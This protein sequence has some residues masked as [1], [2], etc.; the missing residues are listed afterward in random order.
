M[1]RK[2]E[3]GVESSVFMKPAPT[4]MG[5][6]KKIEKET[7]FSSP[8]SEA[9][10]EEEM[11]SD[12]DKG[13]DE[14]AD[15]EENDNDETCQENDDHVETDYFFCRHGTQDGEKLA[16]RST[17]CEEKRPEEFEYIETSLK[18][19]TKRSAC[20]QTT[21]S[22]LIGVEFRSLAKKS[23]DSFNQLQNVCPHGDAFWRKSFEN[24]FHD[25]A[26]AWNFQ[27]HYREILV[28]TEIYGLQRVEIGRMGCM[29]AELWF[30]WFL[31]SND[32]KY[33]KE[34]HLF[35]ST[36]RN[37]AYFGRVAK[38]SQSAK[39]WIE[40]FRFYARFIIVCAI[41]HD[42]P[43]IQK[44]VQE[45]EYLVKRTRVIPDDRFRAVV[46]QWTSVLEEV[47]R[48]RHL[49]LYESRCI[50]RLPPRVSIRDT[51]H[52][53]PLLFECVF[54]ESRPQQVKFSEF[55]VD[56]LRMLR[57]I[58]Q[59]GFISR[60][61]TPS[62]DSSCASD[63]QAESIESGGSSQ[64]SQHQEPVSGS[65]PRDGSRDQNMSAS[66][67][68]G[69]SHGTSMIGGV[70]VDTPHPVGDGSLRKDPFTMDAG[71]KHDSRSGVRDDMEE[72]RR[73]TK[74]DEVRRES[75]AEEGMF[76]EMEMDDHQQKNQKTH[77][78]SGRKQALSTTQEATERPHV[79]VLY[80]PSV[81]ELLTC[82]NMAFL[83]VT[84][85]EKIAPIKTKPSFLLYF[86]CNVV[87]RDAD[88]WGIALRDMTE[89]LTFED[90][91]PIAS[92]FPTVII[93]ESNFPSLFFRKSSLPSNV[94]CLCDPC[95]RVDN[96]ASL[97]SSLTLPTSSRLGQGL[98][99]QF[100]RSQHGSLLTLFL[101]H[102]IFAVAH[103]SGC[104]SAVFDR[105]YD[106]LDAMINTF[107]RE[108]YMWIANP[109]VSRQFHPLI[110]KMCSDEN[111]LNIVIRF[112]FCV[113]FLWFHKAFKGNE[114]DDELKERERDKEREVHEGRRG[115]SMNTYSHLRL[116][117][118]IPSLS[119]ALMKELC[120][121]MEIHVQG[122]AEL[123]EIQ[124]Q[125]AFGSV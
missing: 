24:A 109:V 8:K 63:D 99:A 91:Q 43:M 83:D 119:V 25:L 47:S 87:E 9:N 72:K 62:G 45:L 65:F 17:E 28:H 50:R 52:A 97:A 74:S 122:V 101:Y 42:A 35:Y 40:V 73:E 19:E 114:E 96:P 64:D 46:R 3:N 11:E 15:D 100:R 108:I 66:M 121:R 88:S 54:V 32:E 115:S 41:L 22:E 1:D 49:Y 70:D 34:S 51:G 30:H 18:E 33:L 48:F 125:F 58:R 21:L 120:D 98:L 60:G 124:E 95:A 31:R 53:K 123:L 13:D 37:R 104:S 16:S 39:D 4:E 89:V 117:Y 36:V 107:L 71:V 27:Q 69:V 94:V 92:R 77:E 5:R 10:G 105:E 85:L 106:L 55:S 68:V 6:S 76:G 59:I 82:L 38:Y 116:P 14:G 56:C 111:L 103:C 75:E 23:R 112:L 84:K 81:A 79:T 102:P 93:M 86:S 57:S 80:R 90:I 2:E 118:M 44:L 67:S 7:S 61:Q 113:S 29:L 12:E 110:T 26:Q 20:T 78:E